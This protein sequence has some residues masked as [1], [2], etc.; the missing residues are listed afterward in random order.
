MTTSDR[1]LITAFVDALAHHDRSRLTSLL[2]PDIT[3]RALL[4]SRDVDATGHAAVLTEMLGWFSDLHRVDVLSTEVDLV[5]DIWHAGY[6]FALYGEAHWVTQQH[7]YCTV[8][9][10]SIATLRLICSGYRPAAPPTDEPADPAAPVETA[11]IDAL[12]EGC[13]TLTPRISAAI[14]ELASGDVLSVLTDD[15][16]ARAD[17]SSWSRLTGHAI[18]ASADEERG[19]RFYVRHS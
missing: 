19:T 15:P 18:V 13:S 3:L 2:R 4:P 7:M 17:I 11:R 14:R 5:G 6:R 10:G 12:G 9:D 16:S 1:A 8:A